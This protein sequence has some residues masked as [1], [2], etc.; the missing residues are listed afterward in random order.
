[1]KTKIQIAIIAAVSLCLTACVTSTQTVTQSSS[2]GLVTNT[3]T[4]LDITNT[5]ELVEVSVAAATSIAVIEETNSIAYLR[6]SADA[7]EV[8]AGGTNFTTA[9]L[10]DAITGAAG[11]SDDVKLA[12]QAVQIGL[13]AFD[14]YYR[15]VVAAKIDNQVE[16]LRP[17]ALAIAAGIRDGLGE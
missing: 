2:G 5:A 8:L 12:A 10:T 11:N 17:V 14:S 9:G 15:R 7:I 6:L 16:W 4:T 3:V 13:G 1:M